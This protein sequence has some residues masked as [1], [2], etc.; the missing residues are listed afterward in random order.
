MLS[1]SMVILGIII[2]ILITTIYEKYVS[3]ER[4]KSHVFNIL[5][6]LI[7]KFNIIINL[8]LF[9]PRHGQSTWFQ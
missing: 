9:C 3:F 2:D 7:K 1:V 6:I 5:S 4:H 8:S